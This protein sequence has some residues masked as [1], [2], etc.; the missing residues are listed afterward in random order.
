MTLSL[1]LMILSRI[2]FDSRSRRDA[3]DDVLL[4]LAVVL[5]ELL[6]VRVLR[7]AL[8]LLL[9]EG[10]LDLGVADLDAHLLGLALD[11]DEGGQE[12]Q[13]LVA[14]LVVLLLALVLV[15]LVG[16]R[17][18]ALG[19]LGR[20]LLLV[21]DALGELGRV[22]DGG[23]GLAARLGGDVHPVLE[24]LLLDRLA[25]DRCDGVA[26]YAAT[27]D[28]DGSEC[29]ESAQG[30]EESCNLDHEKALGEGGREYGV[31]RA[32]RAAAGAWSPPRLRHGSGPFRAYPNLSASL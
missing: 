11:P 8:L 27:T 30:Q 2:L 12:R 15:L 23:A 16:R 18:L 1:P 32:L 19:R 14:Q 28:G 4:G 13:D 22:R 25:V 3:L 6:V 31:S 20:R 21:G 5:E 26:G 9:V 10:L 17:R 24:V 29:A 7:E